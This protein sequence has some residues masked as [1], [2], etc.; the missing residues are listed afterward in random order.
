MRASLWAVGR[1][2][3]KRGCKIAGYVANLVLLKF[4]S[5]SQVSLG[6]LALCLSTPAV[7]TSVFV[8]GRQLA[9]QGL[10]VRGGLKE[11]QSGSD[12]PGAEPRHDPSLA[13]KI[14]PGTKQTHKAKIFSRMVS[15]GKAPP[16]SLTVAREGASTQ[17]DSSGQRDLNS[18]RSIFA[19]ASPHSK[20]VS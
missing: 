2:V 18:A 17:V 4:G 1:C 3:R 5:G 13:L 11:G 19:L 12:S 15:C 20:A 7:N 14:M 10:G 16:T 8:H 6:V 9:L